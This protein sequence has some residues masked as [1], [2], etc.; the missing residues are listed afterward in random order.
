MAWLNVICL[1]SNF[2]THTARPR[3]PAEF[4]RLLSFLKRLDRTARRPLGSRPGCQGLASLDSFDLWNC[5][6]GAVK[7]PLHSGLEL[8][9]LFRHSR[10]A[11][12][13]PSIRC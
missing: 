7:D 12:L 4:P 2:S 11:T 9:K 1:P 3:W 10:R 8:S 6:L 5:P 13:Q